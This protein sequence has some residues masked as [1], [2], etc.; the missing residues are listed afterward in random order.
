VST[1]WLWLLRLILCDFYVN[2]YL[3][4]RPKRITQRLMSI[5]TKLWNGSWKYWYCILIEFI[6]HCTVGTF[7][8]SYIFMLVRILNQI[9]GYLGNSRKGDKWA[10]VWREMVGTEYQSSLWK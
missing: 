3:S 6:E 8:K 10:T 7:F 9:F 1:L 4:L 5:F 2:I